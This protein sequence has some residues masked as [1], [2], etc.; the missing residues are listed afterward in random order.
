MLKI[1]F[2]AL[3]V[4][5]TISQAQTL[6]ERVADAPDG[7]VRMSFDARE[8]VCGDGRNISHFRTNDERDVDWDCEAG[9]VRVVLRIRSG[10]VT[11]VDTYVGGSWRPS[12][13]T[14]TDLGFVN[15]QEAADYFLGLAKSDSFADAEDAI[16]PAVI[17]A[18]AVV[19]PQLLAMARE[20]ELS[21]E[22]RQQAV[23]WLGQEAAEEAVDGL[24]SILD[25]DDEEIRVKEQAVFAISQ[26]ETARSISILLRVATSNQHPQVRRNAFFWLAESEDPRAID[27]FEEVLSEN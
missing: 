13:R 6:T 4:A 22:V 15:S 14:V 11:R 19:W 25:D 27:L 18:N 21:N 7:R 20:R 2:V 3:A 12:S 1:A 10:N 9:P 5:G 16:H 8:G 17:A 23:F 26:Q 24:E